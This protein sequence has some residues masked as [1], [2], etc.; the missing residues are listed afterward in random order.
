MQTKIL[1]D[2]SEITFEILLNEIQKYI[3]NNEILK[4]I[5]E[6]Y[7]FAKQ[8]HQGQLRK[9]GQPYIF[10]PIAVSY[11]LALW[12]MGPPTLMAGLLHDVLEDTPATYEEITKHFG[13]EIAELVEAVTKVSYFAKMNRSEIKAN[14]LRKLYLSMARDIRVIV[15]KLADRL[16]NMRTIQYLN[17]TKQQ[18]IAKETLEV[19]STIAHRLGMRQ[20]KTSLEE[21]AFP[22]LYPIE[23][24]K[25]SRLLSAEKKILESLVNKII[26]DI[27]YLLQSKNIKIFYIYGRNKTTYSIYRKMYF[28]GKK[29]EDINDILAIR[30]IT[31]S[32]DDCY[33][34]LG[35]IHQK[36]APLSDG[37]KDYIAT[38]KYNLYQSLHTKIVFN[39]TIYEIQIRTKEMDDQAEHGAAAHWRYKEGENFNARTRQADIDERLNIFKNI[40][41]LEN[42]DNEN[43]DDDNEKNKLEQSIKNDIFNSLIYV[44]TPN[45]KVITLP[46]GSTIL[47][48]AYKI[49]TDIGDKTTGA[50]INGAFV[51]INSVLKSGD[52][53]E[54]KTSKNM[55]PSRGWLLIAKT[56]YAL[57]KI[58]K[59]V[60][61]QDEVEE[62]KT[63]D[64]ESINNKKIKDF[65]E[66]IEKYLE[67]HKLKNKLAVQK[68]INQRLRHLKYLNLDEFYLDAA[69][70]QFNM[71]DVINL[72]TISDNDNLEQFNKLKNKKA[73]KINLKDDIIIK[74]ADNVKALLAHCCM[75]LPFEE[76]K[77]YVTKIQGIRVHNSNCKN[78][79]NKNF[80]EKTIAVYWNED[81]VNKRR[82]NS[83]IKI[84]AIDRPQMMAQITNLLAN[85]NASI[86]QLDA[87]ISNNLVTIEVILSLENLDRLNQIMSSIKQIPDVKEIIRKNN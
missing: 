25:I 42:I 73:S 7:E 2:K 30:I 67:K 60:K 56:N 3:Y 61:K 36:Y 55:R 43:I 20:V 79:N 18:E 17:P 11:S 28:F 76:I 24:K 57:H 47:D 5:E 77:G 19:Y 86:T 78:I 34:T 75:P 35:Y 74:G 21:C 27:K 10:H 53:V 51:P 84:L 33:L 69:N 1:N 85:L 12:R 52:V 22:I 70:G 14:Y 50:R 39:S 23:Y 62:L 8:K 68:N 45:G 48:F 49:H 65:K 64:R 46:F 29:F 81:V 32:I 72:I 58:K 59:A 15:I 66:E 4:K 37:F 9:S 87:R 83:F 40:L 13:E 63:R 41:D 38:P 54:I 80:Q 71:E 82:Y 44:L 16:H 31:N 26:I 6:V